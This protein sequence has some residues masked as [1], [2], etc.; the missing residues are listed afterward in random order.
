MTVVKKGKV[1]WFSPL[2]HYG[3]IAVDGESDVFLHWTVLRAYG[4]LD[5]APDSPITVEAVN[6]EKGWRATRI[7]KL[8]LAP[9]VPRDPPVMPNV[10]DVTQEP[11]RA[12]LKWFD[13]K[14]GYGFFQRDSLPDIFVHATTLKR[15]GLQEVEPGQSM[16]VTHGESAKGRIAVQVYAD[17]R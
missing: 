5:V 10:K 8:E 9:R 2:D 14:R 3:Y 1:K 4:V 11:E 6:S 17:A 15:C 7:I 13:L 12:T 16:L